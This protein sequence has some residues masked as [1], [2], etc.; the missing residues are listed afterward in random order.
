[1]KKFLREYWQ[2]LKIAYKFSEGARR[3][4]IPYERV[5]RGYWITSM[6]I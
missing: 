1:M 6:S 5:N 3:F 4:W 2:L